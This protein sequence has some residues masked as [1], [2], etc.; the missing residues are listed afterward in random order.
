MQTDVTPNQIQRIQIVKADAHSQ[1]WVCMCQVKAYAH[2]QTNLSIIMVQA[3]WIR[4]TTVVYFIES[5][6][7]VYDC[8]RPI[9][10]DITPENVQA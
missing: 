9:E 5:Q 10:R 1:V 6:W 8:E 7:Q 4:K 3:Y 2:R